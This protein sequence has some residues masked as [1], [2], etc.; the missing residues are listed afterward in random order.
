MPSSK[1]LSRRL[2]LAAG[3]R[4]VIVTALAGISL[5]PERSFGAKAAK[6]DYSYRDQ[7]K[8]GKSCADC[9]LFSSGESGKGACALVDGDIS[10]SGW[11]VAFSARK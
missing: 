3:T 9:R 6:A 4:W 1:R 2:A 7:P 11:C 5:V 10:P 8:D